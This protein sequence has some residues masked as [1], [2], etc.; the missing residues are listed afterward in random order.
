MMPGVL[1]ADQTA[2]SPLPWCH[3]AAITPMV[4]PAVLPTRKKTD[5]ATSAS[6]P[7]LNWMMGSPK[8]PTLP[9]AATNT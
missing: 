4:K 6:S 8:L 1:K 5:A 9:N 7:S 2:L 3:V